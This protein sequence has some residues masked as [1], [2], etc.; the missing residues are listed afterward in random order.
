MQT[1]SQLRHRPVLLVASAASPSIVSQTPCGCKS[2]GTSFA[3]R[4][5]D[6]FDFVFY[7]VSMMYGAYNFQGFHTMTR[8][9]QV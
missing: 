7:T 5:L 3:G 1:R 4:W 9:R 8:I 2:L 6:K